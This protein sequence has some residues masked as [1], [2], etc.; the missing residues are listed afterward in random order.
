MTSFFSDESIL[1]IEH[2]EDEH[3]NW[4]MYFDG[5][6]NIHG[7]GIRAVL[8]SPTGDH[9][10][11]AVRLKFP[12]N[13]IGEYETCITSLQEAL[14][15]GIKGLE[16]YGDSILIIAQVTDEWAIKSPELAKYHKSLMH[17]KD[18]FQ[19][20][21]F[22]H[23]SRSKKHFADAL[24]TLATMLK[25]SEDAPLRPI[26]VEIRDEITHCLCIK[27]E[28]DGWPWYYDVKIF[29]HKGIYP[30]SA[31]EL[32]KKTLRCLACQ[33][34]LTCD[35]LYKK[36]YDNVLLRCVNSKDANEIIAEV[37]EGI[38][39]PYMSDHILARKILRMGYYWSTTE[40]VCFKHVRKCHLCQ[41]YTDRIHQPP[42]LLHNMTSP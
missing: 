17:L 25:I 13:N 28:P 21:S 34:F 26:N 20:I 23:V 38:F 11:I 10:P 7:N 9:Y 15:L 18:K 35:I 14:D 24:T 29:L 37:H 16:V 6:V 5:A 31:T 42:A 39:G 19:S 30:N 33:F 2:E 4:R 27:E 22:S 40:N 1:I 41:I 36:S 8:I 3:P 32:D 12:T